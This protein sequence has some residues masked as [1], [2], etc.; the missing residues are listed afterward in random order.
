MENINFRGIPTSLFLNGPNLAIAKDPSNET[1]VVGFAT[2]VGI[3]TV[4]PGVGGEIDSGVGI[5]GSIALKWYFDGSEIKDINEDPTSRAT[6]TKFD[7]ATGYGTTITFNNLTADDA[8]KEVYFT[9]DYIPTAYSQPVG[10]VVNAGSARSTAN[11]TN[12]PLQ[13]QSATISFLPIIE[14]TSQPSDRSIAINDTAIFSVSGKVTP[15][16]GPVEYQWQLNGNDLSDGT[17][18]NISS[19]GSGSGIITITRGSE[20]PVTVNTT[21]IAS[22]DDFVTGEIYTIVADSDIEVDLYAF[23]A[24]GSSNARTDG[25]SGRGGTAKGRFTFIANQTYKLIVGKV[26]TDSYVPS[27]A[28]GAG[29]R[30]NG[31]SNS[32]GGFSGLFIDDVTQANAIIIAGGGGAAAK[33][34]YRPGGNGGFLEADGNNAAWS[35]E[36]GGSQTLGGLGFYD[37]RD[38][39]G[40]Y[41]TLYTYMTGVAFFGGYSDGNA[42]SNNGGGAGGG[43]FG[44]GAGR[45]DSNY[46]PGPY[47]SGGGSSFL[48]PTLLTNG[49]AD[50]GTSD[51]DNA[52][53]SR[54]AGEGGF[55]IETVSAVSQSA[56][57]TI[58]GSKTENLSMTSDTAIN[59]VIRCKLSATGVKESPVFSRSTNYTV[60]EGRNLLNVEQYDYTSSTATL[61][62]VDLSDDSLSISYDSHPGN[63]VCFYAGEQDLDVEIDMYGGTGKGE[64]F[65]DYDRGNN[66]LSGPDIPGGQGG[67]SKIRLTLERDVEYVVTGLFSAVNAPFLYRKG[68]LIAVVGAGGAAGKGGNNVDRGRGGDGGGVNISGADAAQGTGHGGEKIDSGQLPSNGIV[69]NGASLTIITPDTGAQLRAGGRTLP[70]PRGDYWRDQGKSPCEDLGNIKFR[71]PDGTE[72]SSTG[73]ITRGYKSGYNIIQTGA[74]SP[75]G[76]SSGYGGSGGAGATGGRAGTDGGGGGGGSGYTDGS[77]TVVDTQLGGSTG[78]AKIDITLKP[79]PPTYLIVAS[80]GN[81][82][83]GGS[84]TWTINTT[85]VR[86]GTPLYWNVTNLSSGDISPHTGSVTINSDRGSFSTSIRADSTTEGRESFQLVLYTDTARTNEVSRS[87][88]ITINDTSQTPAPPPVIVDPPPVTYVGTFT[89]VFVPFT[90]TFSTTGVITNI[91]AESPTGGGDLNFADTSKKHYLITFSQNV[92]VP[93]GARLLSCLTGRGGRSDCGIGLKYIQRIGSNQIRAWFVRGNGRSVTY[94]R[95]I[96]FK[97]YH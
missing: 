31:G 18:Q 20:T 66:L 44:G 27:L 46:T 96:E 61:S 26:G 75:D 19:S 24:D 48:H 68:S 73:T 78:A 6:I 70:C 40:Q 49:E 12:D 41:G 76:G 54:T 92:N 29:G 51:L 82:N 43:Y 38:G 35:T 60:L 21:Q 80:A 89:H 62:T 42:T 17:N 37:T 45:S 74:I 58:S 56:S 53:N 72:I 81:V 57:I 36:S 34:D 15:G 93:I 5:G 39:T 10:T 9:A 77:V 28:E 33:G 3:A 88:T 91:S 50:G 65:W 94:V 97:L 23:G 83:E 4:T 69:G 71:T 59:G 47:G 11:A 67:Y 63:A 7:D 8:G 32:G 79:I 25:V 95:S 16:D 55:R 30:S 90:S 14:I 87:N 1:E 22:Y 2:F 64:K 84:I 13:S 52:N 85:K 86:D